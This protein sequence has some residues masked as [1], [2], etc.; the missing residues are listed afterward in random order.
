MIG[1]ETVE[2]LFQFDRQGIAAGEDA[3]QT[4]E[5]GIVHRRK[6]QQGFIQGRNTGNEIALVFG[7][8]LGIALGGKARH[9]DAAAAL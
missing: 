9:Q 7:D 1:K 4:A 2:L 3:F 5:V 8:Q 6:T